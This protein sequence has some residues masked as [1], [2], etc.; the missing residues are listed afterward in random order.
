MGLIRLRLFI[1][2]SLT[3]VLNRHG[4]DDDQHLRQTTVLIGR[5]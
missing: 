2:R 4:A 1:G 3:R 5:E